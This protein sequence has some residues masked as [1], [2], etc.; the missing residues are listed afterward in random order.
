ML[1]I[2]SNITT[3]NPVV[4]RIFRDA[5]ADGWRT[6]GPAFARLA[7][8]ASR[9]AAASPDAIAVDTQQHF[10]K[11]EAMEFAVAAAQKAA[12]SRLCL[13]SNNPE[14]I[15]AGLK[16]CTTPPIVNYVSIDKDRLEKVL[17]AASRSRA[18]LVLLVSNP[19]EPA[20]ARDMLEKA[21]ILAG[22]ANA[23]GIPNNMIFVDPGVI[24]ITS[25]AGQHHMAEVLEFLRSLSEAVD[26]EV[27]STCWLSS[28]SSGAPS[29]RR[30]IIETSL[31][32]ELA[33]AGLASVFVDVLRPENLRALRLVKMFEDK[34][35]YADNE[36]EL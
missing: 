11:P 28:S 36:L 17:P 14:A 33:G 9:C 4:R 16:K 26:E 19:A 24:H 8:L 22:A 15:D 25:E 32:C 3:R 30:S 18:G 35:V 31:L 2:A 34:L 13:S 29:R 20:D 6:S 5:S 27:R 10:D 7:D 21:A 1:A 12:K 23:S